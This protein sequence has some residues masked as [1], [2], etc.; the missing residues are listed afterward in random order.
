MGEARFALLRLM[1]E[2]TQVV[3]LV[4]SLPEE[5]RHRVEQGPLAVAPGAFPLVDIVGMPSVVQ[6]VGTGR[7]DEGGNFPI[8][9]RIF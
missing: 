8:R 3:P 1:H 4:V 9:L 6:Q 5:I 2:H 7:S